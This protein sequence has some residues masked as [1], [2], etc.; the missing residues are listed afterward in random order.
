MANFGTAAFV[1]DGSG[2]ISLTFTGGDDNRYFRN[3]CIMSFSVCV[4]YTLVYVR[5]CVF[6]SLNLVS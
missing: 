4:T 6:S 3:G 1:V 5:A 2:G